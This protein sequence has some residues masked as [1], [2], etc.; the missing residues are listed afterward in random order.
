MLFYRKLTYKT[1]LLNVKVNN[2]IT[3]YCVEFYKIVSYKE[4]NNLTENE[5]KAYSCNL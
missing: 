2:R 1:N 5:R 3:R 4:N